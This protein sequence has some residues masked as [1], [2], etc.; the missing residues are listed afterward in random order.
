MDLKLIKIQSIYRGYLYRRN[1]L[2]NSIKLIKKYIEKKK[3]KSE[4]NHP[5]GRINSNIDEINIIDILKQSELFHKRLLIPSPK[6]RH[7]FDIAIYDYQYGL[8]PINIKSST[9]RTSDN[10]GNLAMCVYS[11]TSYDLDINLTTSYNNGIMYPILINY[12]KNNLLNNK[13]KKDYYFIVNNK[14]T[15]EIIIN[16]LKGLK[17]MTSNLNN[18]PFQIK[19][20]HNKNYE[21]KNIDIVINNFKDLFRKNISWK[22][23]FLHEMRCLK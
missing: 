4:D 15:N 20:C 5:D 3:F 13:L 2:P 23:N 19:W 17:K 6:K 8:L 14:Y 16:S 21:Y 12:L 9:T 18:L 7:W 11:L 10:S 22:E 1:S